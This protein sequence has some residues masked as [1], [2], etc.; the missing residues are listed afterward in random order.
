[1]DRYGKKRTTWRART[2]IC[3]VVLFV[4]FVIPL[5]VVL[6]VIRPEQK[7]GADTLAGNNR[8]ESAD[9]AVYTV[10]CE[11]EA[12]S[13][14]VPLETALV[15]MLAGVMDE[16]APAEALRAMAILL[17][18]QAVYEIEQTGSCL[19]QGYEDET[20][21]RE[22][23]GEQ[24]NTY[25]AVYA[26]AAAQTGGIIMTYD[27]KPVETAFHLISAGHTRDPAL[28]G[29]GKVYHWRSVSCEQDLMA[30]EYRT[31]I[32]YPAQKLDACL[33]T[34]TGSTSIAGA[35]IVI[36]ERD[37]TGYVLALSISGG[38]FD[39]FCIGGEQFRTV[40][41]LP[42]SHFTVEQSGDGVR[43]ICFG[44]GHGYGLSIYQSCVL[45]KEGWSCM[46]ILKYFFDEIVFMRIA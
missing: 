6:V 8:E 23:W 3:L 46:D 14:S 16:D 17:R 15:S 32:D 28:L 41:G 44:S 39:A 40:F 29:D 43:F 9:A 38:G 12:G 19:I 33:K 24:Y 22:R 7:N 36:E 25:Y 10:L 4:L 26:D 13:I 45:A 18:T 31:V 34:L 21:L 1:M 2:G 27:G 5:I 42:S 11:Q 35:Q 37:E 20:A 30:K